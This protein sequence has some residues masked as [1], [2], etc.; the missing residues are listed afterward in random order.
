MSTALPSIKL[1]SATS[2]EF[3]E[4]GVLYEDAD[5]LAIDKPARL[6]SS[7]DRYDP[8]RP[9][10]MRLLHEGVEQAK[11]WA[12]SRGLTYLANVHRLDFETSGVFLLAKN[13]PALIELANQFGSEKPHKTYVALIQGSPPEDEFEVDVRLSPDERRVG[14][15][16][17]S[18]E[19]KKSFTKFRVLERF[20]G[21]TFVS[22]HP[23]TGRTHQ[24]RV[25]LKCA[26]YPIYGDESYGG[27]IRL[28]LSD[29]KRGFRLKP[30]REENPLTPS[31]ALHAWKLEVQHPTTKSPV[32]MEAPWPKMLEVAL[33]QLRRH[34]TY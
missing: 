7:P 24:I 9:N 32:A 22:C 4:I 20:E 25:H 1:S 29:F 5:L 19:G 2:R 15:M 14:L 34:G 16:R 18:R 6:L 23:V 17:W 12:A 26:G 10:L 28:L 33:R 31:L 21:V 13:K 30:G 11:P 8:N 27:G 3:W